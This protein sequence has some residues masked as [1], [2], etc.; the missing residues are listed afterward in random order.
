M[1]KLSAGSQPRNQYAQAR[2][3]E[4]QSLCS[5]GDFDAAE[6]I[7]RL[8]IADDKEDYVA[9]NNLGWTLQAGGDLEGA[10]TCYLRSLSINPTYRVAI[11]NLLLCHLKKGN[12][13]QCYSLVKQ[14]ALKDPEIVPWLHQLVED[15]MN[16]GD[17]SL[18]ESLAVSIASLRNGK[19]AAEDM[20][21]YS[22]LERPKLTISKLEHDAQQFRYLRMHNLLQEEYDSVIDAYEVTAAALKSSGEDNIDLDPIQHAI[23][24]ETYNRVIYKRDSP[25]VERALSLSWDRQEAEQQYFENVPG[26]V[27][28]DDFLSREALDEL[29]KFCVESTVWSLNRYAHGR[30]GSF[31]HDGFNSPLLMQ[32]TDEIRK[33]LPNVI[34]S[35]FPLRQMWA[36]KYDDLPEN[37]TVHADFAAVNVNFWITPDSANLETKSGGLVIYDVGAPMEWSFDLYNGDQEAIKSFL[38]DQGSRGYTIPYRQNR[39]IIFNSDLFH[40]TAE[41][42]FKKEYAS[43]RVNV[44]M[45]YGDR[46]N[47]NIHRHD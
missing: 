33:A 27:V 44:T 5:N 18:A 22:S 38:K 7:F 24:W 12:T 9:H 39:A 14:S 16:F 11:Q 20:D 47:D 35:R 31:F 40:A 26:V 21:L 46:E 41:V 36:F 10:V 2:N 8:A 25:R 29:Q 17:L 19:R 13:Q 43:R 28:I 1:G 42:K 4:A 37:S 45:L 3:E 23:I 30:L 15:A 34:G 32:I 6:V